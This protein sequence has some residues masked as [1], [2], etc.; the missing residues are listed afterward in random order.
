VRYRRCLG[1]SERKEVGRLAEL[2]GR[3]PTEVFKEDFIAVQMTLS[4]PRFDPE[5]WPLAAFLGDCFTRLQ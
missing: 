3:A 4:W 1:A 5:R 2:F